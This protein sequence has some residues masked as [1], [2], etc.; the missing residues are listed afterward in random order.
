MTLRRLLV[1]GTC[2]ALLAGACSSRGEDDADG[3]GGSGTTA[4]TEADGG[5]EDDGGVTFGDLASP[6][7]PA[8]DDP[9]ATAAS[10]TAT[11]D[12]PGETQGVGADAIQVGTIADPGFSGQP[13]LNQEIFDAGDAF[14]AWCNDQGGIN[15]RQI[16]LTKYDAAISEYQTQMESACSQE[17][18][19]VGDGA[20]QDNL[21][22]TV[23]AACGLIDIAGFSVTAEKGGTSGEEVWRESRAVQPLPNPS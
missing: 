10:D 6:C 11:S 9:S 21:W 19:I 13:G 20:V 12:D 2:L 14:V 7:G 15:G 16:E 4:T 5:A 8:T 1:V 18:A 22:A 17:F 23:G 3:G